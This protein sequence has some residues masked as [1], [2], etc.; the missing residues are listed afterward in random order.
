MASKVSIEEGNRKLSNL[1][2]N[3]IY[4]RGKGAVQRFGVKIRFHGLPLRIG[5][6]YCSAEDASTVVSIFRQIARI[7]NSGDISFDE[8]RLKKCKDVYVNRYL[9]FSSTKNC[10]SVL[11]FLSEWLANRRSKSSVQT[12]SAL[13]DGKSK[14]TG[15]AKLSVLGKH[16]LSR[17]ESTNSKLPRG[18]MYNSPAVNKGGGGEK[19]LAEHG[20]KPPLED[21]LLRLNDE[22]FHDHMVCLL[23]TSLEKRGFHREN[24]YVGVSEKRVR[25]KNWKHEIEFV[26]RTDKDDDFVNDSSIGSY[27][28]EEHDASSSSSIFSDSDREYLDGEEKRLFALGNRLGGMSDIHIESLTPNKLYHSGCELMVLVTINGF[29]DNDF[30]SQGLLN[31]LH[32][33]SGAVMEQKV[34]KTLFGND[35]CSTTAYFALDMNKISVGKYEFKLLAKDSSH[36]LNT[37]SNSVDF[38]VLEPKFYSSSEGYDASHS[39]GSHDGDSNSG[40]DSG[41]DF[42]EK[43]HGKDSRNFSEGNSSD[44]FDHTGSHGAAPNEHAKMRC[45]T[46]GSADNSVK[47]GVFDIESG[48]SLV[49]TKVRRLRSSLLPM[50]TTDRWVLAFSILSLCAFIPNSSRSTTLK[51]DPY[52]HG[53][54]S[55][56]ETL[57]LTDISIK[58]CS[59]FED[60]AVCKNQISY[61]T[62]QGKGEIFSFGPEDYFQKVRDPW[63]GASL[64]EQ[65]TCLLLPLSNY[66]LLFGFPQQP[67]LRD[68]ASYQYLN[69]LTL[70]EMLTRYV[71]GYSVYFLVSPLL[72]LLLSIGME[73][74]VENRWSR[75]RYAKYRLQYRSFHVLVLF[76]CHFSVRPFVTKYYGKPGI[77]NLPI[78]T[79]AFAPICQ[80]VLAQSLPLLMATKKSP[81]SVDWLVYLG[82]ASL[83]LA[84]TTALSVDKFDAHTIFQLL[85]Y[86]MA[87]YFVAF[88]IATAIR[89]FDLPRIML[90]PFCRSD[91]LEGWY[92]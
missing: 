27:S 62:Q 21:E 8:K 78:V 46:H 77:E 87:P 41:N 60:E 1:P 76:L 54:F 73:T 44:S 84:F 53:C 57:G 71:A 26:V 67:Y 22:E 83:V 88:S 36:S 58:A 68:R 2:P 23:D 9:P 42:Q 52:L 31:R 18:G 13:R 14:K 45:N 82:A 33:K 6:A 29:W 65:F 85:P 32:P 50:L 48:L 43:D 80:R 3:V 66:I 34:V 24:N 28:T 10:I 39:G 4:T 7:G 12:G 5:S 16:Q 25:W 15:K 64:L 86:Y 30:I 91:S 63:P 79:V 81:A 17:K 49:Y 70:I 90:E 92:F 19:V 74:Y 20:K 37:E 59:L 56:V 51:T 61:L 55:T 89:Y 47:L 35:N 38:E 11:D 40:D 75:A 72:A 69:Y